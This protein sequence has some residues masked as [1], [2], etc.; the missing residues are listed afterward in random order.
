MWA[1]ASAAPLPEELR[2][3]AREGTLA[4]GAAAHIGAEFCGAQECRVTAHLSLQVPAQAR[5][6]AP[7]ALSAAGA[8]CHTR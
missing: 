2:L 1:L 4:P 8:S 5:A 3:T 7:F 6:R